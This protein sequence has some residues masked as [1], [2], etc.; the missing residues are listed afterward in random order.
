MS[1]LVELSLP[2]VED[3][4]PEPAIV[5]V[6]QA[7]GVEP[8]ESSP[9]RTL[10]WS[11][12]AFAEEQI[13]GLVRQLFLPGGLS[14]SRQVLFTPVDIETEIT[15]ICMRVGQVLAEQG[16]GITCVVETQPDC[17]KTGGACVTSGSAFGSCQK[18][19][20]ALRDSSQQ[21]SDKLWFMPGDVFLS[22]SDGNSSG[23]W[24]RARLAEL[25]LE[26]DYTVL[27]GPA[28]A[29]SSEAAVLG[30]LC[31]GAVLVLEANSTRRITAERAKE[32]LHA[33][34]VRLLGTV[35]SERTFP[36]PEALYR[37]L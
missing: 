16:A 23:V 1:T 18:R 11:P 25:R 21:L 27:R 5:E 6:E 34:N 14:P 13:R 26:F 17:S 33:A 35:L 37:R 31:D 9:A 12:A 30:G 8:S 4:V 29:I 24:L 15:E 3:D 20:G 2:V 19:F 22:G 36:V 32:R 10:A 7:V 28:A